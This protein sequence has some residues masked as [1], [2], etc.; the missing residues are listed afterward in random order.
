MCERVFFCCNEQLNSSDR[1]NYLSKHLTNKFVSH[2]RLAS[3]SFGPLQARRNVLVHGRVA[4][5]FL[6]WL[7][8][9]C[10]QVWSHL[11]LLDH[12]ARLVLH[13]S[14]DVRKADLHL[15]LLA[16]VVLRPFDFF[17]LL[18]TDTG[19]FALPGL[20]VPLL[21]H[22]LIISAKQLYLLP[23]SPLWHRLGTLL[24]QVKS[25]AFAF[26]TKNKIVSMAPPAVT[27]A[28]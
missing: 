20:M 18:R 27:A 8:L 23:L 14:D 28:I 16:S 3:V 5:E 12:H 13:I 24:E 17:L 26:C 7:R 9:R 1:H 15:L 19:S 4:C 10:S 22:V 6:G 21:L 11:R 2:G 25:S